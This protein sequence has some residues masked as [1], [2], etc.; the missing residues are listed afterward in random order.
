MATS[1][2]GVEALLVADDSN[3]YDTAGVDYG[4]SDGGGATQPTSLGS[5]FINKKG[6]ILNGVLAGKGGRSSKEQNSE[7]NANHPRR[8]E[9]DALAEDREPLLME[10][11]LREQEQEQYREDGDELKEEDEEEDDDDDDETDDDDDMP[12]N[13]HDDETMSV[14]TP[15]SS[16]VAA[17]GVAAA[18]TAAVATTATMKKRT[19][20]G[21]AKRAATLAAASEATKAEKSS[22]ST[23]SKAKTGTVVAGGAAAGAYLFHKHREEQNNASPSSPTADAS[24]NTANSGSTK[25][26]S[27]CTKSKSVPP[28]PEVITSTANE[29]VLRETAAPEEG[30]PSCYEE[31]AVSSVLPGTTQLLLKLS[32]SNIPSISFDNEANEDVELGYE[33]SISDSKKKKGKKKRRFACGWKCACLLVTACMIIILGA[34]FGLLRSAQ[35]RNSEQKAADFSGGEPRS[36]PVPP[37]SLSSSVPTFKPSTAP[38]VGASVSV[39]PTPLSTTDK[40]VS[41][42]PTASTEDE[43]VDEKIESIENRPA[44]EESAGAITFDANQPSGEDDVPTLTDE[45]GFVQDAIGNAPVA[46]PSGVPMTARPTALMDNTVPTQGPSA[47]SVSR[48]P[49]KSPSASPVSG[50]PTAHENKGEEKVDKKEKKKGEKGEKEEDGDGINTKS[51]TS[52]TKDPSPEPSLA[53]VS[54]PLTASPVSDPPTAAPVTPEPSSA[55]VSD[56]LTASPVSDLP[57]AAAVTPEPSSA[58]VSDSAT[59]SLVSDLPTAAPGTSKPS[60]GPTSAPV[61]NGEDALTESTDDVSDG[62]TTD[63]NIGIAEGDATEEKAKKDKKSEKAEKTEMIEN[64]GEEKV[65]KK[66]KKKGEKSEKEED[67]DGINTK[68]ETSATKDPSPE[69]SLAPVSDPPTASPVSDPPTA[70]P[71]TPEPSSAPVSDP[72]TASPVSDPPTAVP[73]PFPS[74]IPSSNPTSL[75]TPLPI[76]WEE[77]SPG[78]LV[79]N[80]N[81]DKATD[82]IMLAVTAKASTITITSID[83][84]LDS[85]DTNVPVE[86]MI[87]Q[88]SYFGYE[89]YSQIWD[90]VGSYIIPQ[91]NGHSRVTTIQGLDPI[92]IASGKTIGLYILFPE[93]HEMLIGSA[94]EITSDGDIRIYSGS[95]VPAKFMSVER[96]VGWSGAIKYDV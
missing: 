96:G 6:R 25:P 32:P 36:F 7:K 3:S 45:S 50:S 37:T 17:T 8:Y 29:P 89:L 34:F 11:N 70:A 66:E 54:D 91:G 28:R 22:S 64:K 46:T 86:V 31:E 82:G 77:S 48:S 2:A 42:S 18:T 60:P 59:A 21:I 78:H 12:L 63:T 58:P 51:E 39:Q 73:T 35:K 61:T 71:V 84:L 69:P 52:A 4:D 62:S 47:S 65:D 1:D 81:R 26:L 80:N 75:P 24:N 57:T 53:P 49:T 5:K 94:G 92:T 56:P 74:T 19:N 23:Q 55:P 33:E 16:S 10:D 14:L 93:G 85:I 43:V 20:G 68:A 15:R 40:P 76:V 30:K 79:T 72:P 27:G 44:N 38:V 9:R 88:G 67:G 83:I 41:A 90:T 95:S 87:T 13:A